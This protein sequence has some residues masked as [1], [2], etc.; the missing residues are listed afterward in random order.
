MLTPTSS[1]TARPE[2]H[3]HRGCRGLLPENTLPAFHRAL[4][5]GVDALELDVVVSQ[6]GQLLVSHEPWLAAKLGRG[7]QG[8]LINPAQE[9]SYNLYQMPYAAIAQCTVGEWPHPDFALQQP[10][11]S[12]RPLLREVL[13]QAEVW[14]QQL[15][16]PA[17]RYSVEVKSSP[18]G[19]DLFHPAPAVFVDLVLAALQAAGIASRTTLLSFDPRVLRAAHQAMPDLAL[20]LLIEDYLPPVAE[21]FTALGFEPTTLGPDFRLLSAAPT[22][23]AIRATYPTLRLVPWT[24]NSP[25]DLRLVHSWGVDGITTDY[26]DRLLALLNEL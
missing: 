6:D 14:C 25:A 7:P 5:L 12:H 16:R 21:L 18:D 3:G 23:Q 11:L 17:V 2:V 4:E 22:V 15:G 10:T 9:R 20:C 24:V 26:P 13:H 19:D 1:T 8:E